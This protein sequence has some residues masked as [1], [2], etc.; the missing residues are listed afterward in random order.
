MQNN[1]PI[2]PITDAI[3]RSLAGQNNNQQD[4][5]QQDKIRYTASCNS[6]LSKSAN[7]TILKSM[8]SPDPKNL[9][10]DLWFEDEI[11]C[12]FADSNAGKSILAVQLADHIS[13]H[14]SVLYLDC[15]LTA[16]Q[17]QLRYTDTATNQVHTFPDNFYRAELNPEQID[18]HRYEE[19]IIHGLIQETHRVGAKIIIIDNL[20]YLCTSAEKGESAGEFMRLLRELRSNYGYSILIIAHTPKRN[21]STPITQNNLA[22]SKLLY[23]YFDSCFAI[24]MSSKGQDYRYIKQIKVRNGQYIYTA[25]NVLTCRLVKKEAFLHFEYTGT[26]PESVHLVQLSSEYQQERIQKILSLHKEGLT[27]RG[28]ARQMGTTHTY[29]NNILTKYKNQLDKTDNSSDIPSN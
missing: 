27:N 14:E 12:L 11:C 26:E 7:Q 16:K 24:G 10:K 6:L 18:P 19:C 13:Q 1:N 2:A 15:E 3:S 5:N 21:L 4:N 29:V 17:F 22:G 23:N 28:I 25:S 20:S 9:Y 8:S